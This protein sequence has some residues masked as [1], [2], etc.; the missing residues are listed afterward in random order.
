MAAIDIQPKRFVPTRMEIEDGGPNRRARATMC[1]FG[2]PAKRHEDFAIAITEEDLIPAQRLAFMNEIQDYIRVVA[3]KNVIS[4]SPH[5]HG[6]GI[7]RL[8]SPC[9]RDTLVFNSPHWIGDHSFSLANHDE[10]MNCRR[11]DFARV[12]WV[13]LVGYSLDYKEIHFIHQACNPIGWVIHWHS[14]DSSKDR[15]L[16]KV[17]IE[18][19]ANVPRVMKLKSGRALDGEGRSW[20]VRVFILNSQFAYQILDED[21]DDFPNGDNNNG[22]QA[23]E[24]EANFVANLADPRAM[25]SVDLLCRRNG[26]PTGS[27]GRPPGL[28]RAA[29]PPPGRPA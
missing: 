1:F 17:L 19:T 24:E 22:V 6:I 16:V 14:N 29:R 11:S 13:M 2:T 5:P 4:Y 26:G 25:R 7:Y 18:N 23:N 8:E 28:P 15:V 10:A 27:G 12:G 21:E 9:D 3:R 20:A